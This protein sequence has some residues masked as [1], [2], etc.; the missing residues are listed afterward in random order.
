MGTPAFAEGVFATLHAR[1][2]GIPRRINVL[3]TRA[4]LACSLA[5]G[6]EITPA[7]IGRAADELAG[8]L[9]ISE[10][11]EIDRLLVRLGKPA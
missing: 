11:S 10:S 9:G 5:G 4:L 1:S 6:C 2:G 3:C 8:E 7:D